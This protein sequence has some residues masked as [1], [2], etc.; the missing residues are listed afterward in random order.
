[1][2]DAARPV[3]EM[4]VVR[5]RRNLRERLG[6]IWRSRELL[7]GLARKDLK[8]RYKNSALGFAW[9][10]LNPLLF[11]AIFYVAFQLVLR[12]GIPQ[13]PIWLLSGL[14]VWNL[15]SVGLTAATGSVTANAEIVKKVAFPREI[16]PLAAIG[17]ALVHFLL[18]AL[19]LA[20]ALLLYRH[21]VAW[22]YLPLLPFALV[23]LLVFGAGL[24]MLLAALNVRMRDTQHF[25]ELA[26]LAWFWMTPIVYQYMAMGR[27]HEEQP[28]FVA[29]YTLNPIVPVVLTFQR[30]I[31][32]RLDITTPSSGGGRLGELGQV[33]QLLPHWSWEAYA[34]LLTWTLGLGIILF[35]VGMWAF[36]RYEGDFAEE[37]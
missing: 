24:G 10:L 11:L 19:V 31:Y 20:A 17:A 7:V 28:F 12:V 18:Q 22:A 34:L 5:A 13:F 27:R 33:T 16:L 6:D 21:D 37:L 2:D 30:T 3:P 4:R 36:A 35:F 32:N 23:A 8:V 15:F 26:L 1:V 14:L 9:S 29:L 25:V